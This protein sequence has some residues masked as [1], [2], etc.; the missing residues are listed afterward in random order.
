[1]EAMKSD[2][3]LLRYVSLQVNVWVQ[4]KTGLSKNWTLQLVRAKFRGNNFGKNSHS[5]NLTPNEVEQRKFGHKHLKLDLYEDLH[6]LEICFN[7]K[8]FLKELVYMKLSNFCD[9]PIY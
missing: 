7:R 3:R 8:W 6:V 4:N 5:K 9:N 1:M 2:D